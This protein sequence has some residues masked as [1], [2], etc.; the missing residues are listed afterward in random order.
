MA[1]PKFPI[2]L[3]PDLRK[4]I[5]QAATLLNSDSA[6]VVRIGANLFSKAVIEG[7]LTDI[8]LEVLKEEH[9]MKTIKKLD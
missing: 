8:L 6:T 3:T 2:T 9:T 4:Q 1:S 5:D 7:K